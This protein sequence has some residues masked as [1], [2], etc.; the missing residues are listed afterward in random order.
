MLPVISWLHPNTTS[1]IITW[2]RNE[3]DTLNNPQSALIVLDS[4]GKEKFNLNN[5][6]KARV[7]SYTTEVVFINLEQQVSAYFYVVKH[8]L[9]LLPKNDKMET[10]KNYL[11]SLAADTN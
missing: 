6:T 10:V 4:L 3:A 11:L 9:L 7:A 8:S 1:Q 2:F 5:D